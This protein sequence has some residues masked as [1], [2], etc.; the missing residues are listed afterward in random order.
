[1][2]KYT[3]AE[4]RARAKLTQRAL[5]DASGLTESTIANL[6]IGRHYNPTIRTVAKLALALGIDPAQLRFAELEAK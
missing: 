1:M 4:A 5:S 2:E 6:E 3:L